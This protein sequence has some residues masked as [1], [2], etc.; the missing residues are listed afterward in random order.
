MTDDFQIPHPKGVT[1]LLIPNGQ[2]IENDYLTDFLTKVAS[3]YSH[4]STPE[5]DLF[6]IEQSDDLYKELLNS[7]GKINDNY[8]KGLTMITKGKTGRIDTVDKRIIQE[9]IQA[10][11]SLRVPQSLDYNELLESMEEQKK[12]REERRAEKAKTKAKETSEKPKS[13]P[14]RNNEKVTERALVKVEEKN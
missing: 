5:G 1:H 10:K 6:M 11:H 3:N 12:I 4:V 14:S 9:A 2:S 8:R 13:T 7:E